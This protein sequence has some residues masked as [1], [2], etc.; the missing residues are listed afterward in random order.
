[1]GSGCLKVTKYFLFLFNLLFFIL[2][3]V[4]LG[5]G[6]WI[7]FDKLTFISAL[8]TSSD[9]FKIGAYILIAVGAVTILMGFLGCIGAV[10]E[11]RCLLGV[12]FTCLLL[13]F[14]AQ[15]AAGLLIYFQQ[16][17]VKNEMSTV[18][19][20]LIQDYDPDSEEKK[21]IQDAWD[22]VQ[23][24]L[25]CCG[26]DG[27]KDWMNNTLLKNESYV[28]YPCSCFSNDSSSG[29]C[30]MDTANGTLGSDWWP[31]HSK[32]CM[33]GVQSWLSDNL[34]IILGVCTGVAAIELLGM[35]L[36]ISLCKN[37]HN[38]DYTKVPKS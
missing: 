1:M 33:D 36:S 13:I 30:T 38:E 19:Q 4:I 12:Y 10:N 24:Q 20:S 32:G 26:W 18:V 22:Y 11:I 29:F 16:D 31:V 37:I 2:G 21:N 14:L 8:K 17:R 35:L 7:L 6:I 3:A 28:S 23:K 15:I 25:Y 34:G 27:P 9:S 5:F